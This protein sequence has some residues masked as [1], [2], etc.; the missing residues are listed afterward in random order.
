MGPSG[1]HTKT[2]RKVMKMELPEEWRTFLRE[3]FPEG[4]RIRLRASV[5]AECPVEPGSMGVLTG[6]SN[7]GQFQVEWENGTSSHLTAAD[8]FSV[9]PPEPETLKF[10]VPLNAEV[11]ER[12]EYGDFDDEPF[13]LDGRDLL[14][15]EDQIVAQMVRERMPEEAERGLMHWYSEVDSVEQKV[16]SAVFTAESR[17]GQ[18]WGVAEC[19]VIGKLSH[20]E[21][22]TLRGYLEGQM[23]D[24]WGEGFEQREIK[25]DNG[26][27]YV[28]LWDSGI[29]WS[30]ET[31]E[32]RFGPK[33]EKNLPQK[34]EAAKKRKEP[35]R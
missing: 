18:L 1:V 21:L 8:K 28:H 32:E 19:Q 33:I 12:N 23:A 27:M 26:E 17:A 13:D 11:F 34:P 14:G 2:E 31:E 16:R 4:S 20:S 10:Y 24:G 3:Q 22:D 5:D 35:S 29:D 15:Y 25:V 9:L 7:D 6:I 30:I